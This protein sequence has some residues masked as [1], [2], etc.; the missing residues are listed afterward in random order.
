MRGSSPGG[1]GERVAERDMQHVNVKIFA[2]K[3]DGVK[4]SDAIQVFHRWIQSGG[5]P[6]LL[7]D[8]ADYCHVPAG[9]GVVLIAH[10]AN[11][12]LDNSRD[13]LGLLYNRKSAGGEQDHLGLSYDAAAAACQRLE[14]E[15]EFRGR[16]RFDRGD[17]E[18]TLNDRLLHP[19][20][21]EGWEEIRPEVTEFFDRLFGA[22][23]YSIARAS[24]DPRE[25]LRLTIRRLDRSAS[26]D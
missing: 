20:T 17:V 5:L 15:P 19:N 24:A 11:Y 10:D 12:S 16:L 21:D 18:V 22:G 4:L 26:Q 6:E 23:S 3:A 13:R 9:P 14:Q 1:G 7:I 2:E 8:V 25:R